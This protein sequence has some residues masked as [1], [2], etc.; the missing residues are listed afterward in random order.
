MLDVREIQ[1]ELLL[2]ATQF[3]QERGSNRL[4]NDDGGMDGLAGVEGEAAWKIIV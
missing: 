4:R 1:N 3:T 2:T